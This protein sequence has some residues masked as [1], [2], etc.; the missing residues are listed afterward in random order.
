MAH[1]PEA[2]G[3]ARPDLEATTLVLD[4]LGALSGSVDGD[5]LPG[6]VAARSRR[7]QPDAFLDVQ[8]GAGSGTLTSAEDDVSDGHYYCVHTEPSTIGGRSEH[9][10]EPC[11]GPG[12]LAAISASESHR[13]MAR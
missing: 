5:M 10:A 12:H 7:R 3:R 9:P 2:V 4:R 6:L 13:S 8:R 1:V 11:V